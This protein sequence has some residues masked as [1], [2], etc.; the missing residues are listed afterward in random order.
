LFEDVL[1]LCESKRTFL[2]SG[3]L[4]PDGD[5]LGTE[6]ALYHFLKGMGK[7][8]RILN[9]D[10]VERC[11]DFLE[12]HTPFEVH[13]KGG[14]LPGHEVHCL[15]DC[16][17]L[18][19]LGSVGEAAAGV[20]GVTRLVVDHHI[21]ADRGDGDLLLFDVAAPSAGS[22]VY[23]LHRKAGA[24]I[25]MPAAE[26]I[27]VSLAADTGWFRYS[28]TDDATFAIAADL[29]ARGLKPHELYDALYRRRQRESIPILT[30]ALSGASFELEGR[31]AV[32]LLDKELMRRVDG[33]DFQTDEILEQLRSIEGVEIVLLL[34]ELLDGRIKMSLRSTGARDV[35]RL[36]RRFGGGGHA[37]AAG[38]ELE[39]PLVRA[40]DAAIEALVEEFGV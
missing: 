8:V 37:K 39:G 21:G 38:A 14:E 13:S 11:Y 35:D 27:F 9:A 31:I 7:D 24:P 25:S 32:C 30:E 23:D 33:C 15:V 3:H 4:R 1:A 12:R 6:V 18:S 17:T 5:C 22:L 26:G 2:I 10:R 19:R 36:A 28:N 20:E 16:S 40:R 29:V 34:K